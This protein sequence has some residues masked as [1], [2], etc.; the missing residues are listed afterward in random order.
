MA[1]LCPLHSTPTGWGWLDKRLA[2][3]VKTTYP[4]IRFLYVPAACTPVAQPMDAG[5]IAKMKGLLRAKYSHWA[6]RVTREQIEGGSEPSKIRLPTDVQMCK[7]NL[8][9]WLGDIVAVMN[10]DAQKESVR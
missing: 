5:I 10:T 3:W 8:V 9:R 4:W 6:C 1:S 2:A 7:T